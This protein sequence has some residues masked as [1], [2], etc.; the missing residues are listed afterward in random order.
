MREYLNYAEGWASFDLLIDQ[1]S[2]LTIA[3]L[4][5]RARRLHRTS[6]LDLVVIDYLQLLRGI[7]YRGRNRVEEIGEI[8][9]GLKALAKELNI[10]VIAVSQLS[11]APEAREDKRPQ[12]SDLR[13]SGDIEQD[14]DVVMFVFREA[15]YLE[16]QPPDPGE[17]EATRRWHER[18][19]AARQRGE[20]IVAKHRNG[21]I[22]IVHVRVCPITMR[23]GDL[24]VNGGRS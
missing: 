13:A 5:A 19:Q 16:R 8:T 4:R 9:G 7:A 12:L 11:R 10:P 2:A 15:Y 17:I 22:G 14:A 3:Q 21:P 6:R 24:E 23:F 18:L 20:I 1:S